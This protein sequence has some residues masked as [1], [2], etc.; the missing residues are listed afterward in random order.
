MSRKYGRIK[1]HLVKWQEKTDECTVFIL[2]AK[3]KYV[4]C[5]SNNSNNI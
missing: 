1:S 5:M 3:E 4:R 2:D